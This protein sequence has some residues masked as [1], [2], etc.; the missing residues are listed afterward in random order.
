MEQSKGDGAAA[1]FFQMSAKAWNGIPQPGGHSNFIMRYKKVVYSGVCTRCGMYVRLADP[2]RFGKSGRR[3]LAGF[4]NAQWTEYHIF[5]VRPEIAQE[6]TKAGISGLTFRPA[7]DYR[8]GSGLPDRVQMLFTNIIP[9][10]EISQLPTVTCR[11]N[12]EEVLAIQAVFDKHKSA[13]RETKSALPPD[14]LR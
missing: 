12:N 2:F 7:L 11:P 1:K 10:A 3:S 13:E 9:C 8:S 6:I 14:V 4:C 5:F